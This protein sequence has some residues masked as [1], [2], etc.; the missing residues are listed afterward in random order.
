ML[1][2]RAFLHS[3]LSGLKMFAAAGTLGDG[4]RIVHLVT[5]SPGDPETGPMTV[6][7]LDPQRL[8]S[9][10]LL[11]EL[12]DVAMPDAFESLADI[13]RDAVR[14][15]SYPVQ[16]TPRRLQGR[17]VGTNRSEPVSIVEG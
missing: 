2:S 3:A 9:H 4:S 11:S 13:W 17:V 12:P 15:T 7:P 10:F 6:T 14:T 8:W 16:P 5:H 1:S